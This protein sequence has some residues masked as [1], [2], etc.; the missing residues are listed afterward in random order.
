MN[1]KMFAIFNTETFFFFNKNLDINFCSS[2]LS[3]SSRRKLRQMY[4]LSFSI[5]LILQGD[6]QQLTAGVPLC[7]IENEKNTSITITCA[8]PQAP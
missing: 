8:L 1:L 5:N 3:R 2:I 4:N 7:H 6:H